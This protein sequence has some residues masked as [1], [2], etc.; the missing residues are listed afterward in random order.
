MTAA[1]FS[2]EVRAQ[3][4]ADLADAAIRARLGE[5]DSHGALNDAVRLLQS[6]A[7]KVRRRRPAD[8]ALIDAQLAGLITRLA[9][10]LHAFRPVRPRG[11]P[12]VPRPCDLTGA[13]ETALSEGEEPQ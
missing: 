11:A 13:Y 2:V 12:R 4:R 8:A 10:Q 9:S 6:E 3:R 7:A 1:S 5:A